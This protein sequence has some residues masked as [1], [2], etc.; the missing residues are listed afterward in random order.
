MQKIT[1]PDS[2]DV[3]EDRLNERRFNAMPISLEQIAAFDEVHGFAAFERCQIAE[4]RVRLTK[5]KLAESGQISPLLLERQG[6]PTKLAVA[7][8]EVIHGPPP[9]ITRLTGARK[10]KSE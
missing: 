7:Y 3:L 9:L 4:R 6:L 10:R 5:R 2:S 1:I 8:C